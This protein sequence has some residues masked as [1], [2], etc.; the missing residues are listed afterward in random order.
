[1]SERPPLWKRA[2]NSVLG[3]VKLGPSK[4]GGRSVERGAKSGKQVM[5]LEN[6]PRRD[7]DSEKFKGEFPM[8]P[9]LDDKGERRNRQRQFERV[10]KEAKDLPLGIQRAIMP[11]TYGDTPYES[12]AGGKGGFRDVPKDRG[13]YPIPGA[14]ARTYAT[15]ATH[16]AEPTEFDT[17][18]EDDYRFQDYIYD[19]ER[20]NL[21]IGMSWTEYANK[22]KASR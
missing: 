11:N 4:V 5:T 19:Q 6:E 9:L 7:W 15:P 18:E 14:P 16:Q 10:F 8:M 3:T 2:L 12:P 17:A 13:G 1:M 22:I 21:P 20:G